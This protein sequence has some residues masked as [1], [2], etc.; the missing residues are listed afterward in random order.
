MSLGDSVGEVARM[1][2]YSE[3]WTRE[4]ARRYESEGVVRG[5]EIAVTATLGPRRG[6]CSMRRDKHSFERP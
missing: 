5:L 4:I 6:R 1:V 2:G 3:K